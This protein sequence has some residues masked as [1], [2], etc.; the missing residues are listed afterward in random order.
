M[1][2]P[3]CK[4][5]LNPADDGSYHCGRCEISVRSIH[6][7]EPF[8]G[9]N[10]SCIIEVNGKSFPLE[11]EVFMVILNLNRDNQTILDSRRQWRGSAIALLI[12]FVTMTA[13]CIY[14][15]YKSL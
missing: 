1:N 11:K 12:G 5:K 15:K 9:E 14:L 2:C 6:H 3:D 10:D 13:C 7:Q 8:L 4:T